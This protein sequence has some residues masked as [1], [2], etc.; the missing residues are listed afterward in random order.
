M[1]LW[2]VARCC[3]TPSP[4]RPAPTPRPPWPTWAPASIGWAAPW[5]WA[6]GWSTPAAIPPWRHALTRGRGL[7]GAAHLQRGRCSAACTQPRRRSPPLKPRRPL[8][9]GEG[10][11]VTA[12][13]LPDQPGKVVIESI[14]GD[15]GRLTLDPAKNC[16]GVAATE[17]LKLL[18]QVSC[19]VSLKLNKVRRVRPAA[20]GA[21]RGRPGARPSPPRHPPQPPARALQPPARALRRAQPSPLQQLPTPPPA[22]LAGPAA[23]QR[24]GQQRRQRGGG[25]RGGQRRVWQPS[26]QGRARL[27]G[28]G[29]GG[30][31]FGVPRRQR[32]ARADGRLC[33]GQVRAG[34]HH[35][36][37][38]DALLAAAA[39]HVPQLPAGRP[40]APHPP[41]PRAA[42]AGACS[43]W[44]CC[45]CRWAPPPPT[46]GLCWSTP[47]SRRPPPR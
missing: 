44:S 18:G 12:T 21:A 4:S 38:V 22:P 20:P 1:W 7:R 30:G 39:A 34:A 9:Q 14:T 45:G 26:D 32:G 41:T 25:G 29:F 42:P 27:R 36:A 5:R 37:L 24:H 8:P 13:V 6:A 23:G 19:G 17:T 11:T 15:G 28:P 40:P 10:D 3:W 47:N 33:A 35:P 16:I 2:P 43:R 31:G 46:C